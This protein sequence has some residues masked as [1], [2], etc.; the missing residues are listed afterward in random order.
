MSG[1]KLRQ[2]GLPFGAILILLFGPLLPYLIDY[3]FAMWPCGVALLFAALALLAHT[4]LI[5]FCRA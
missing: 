3:S 5:P 1:S 2:F 4:A